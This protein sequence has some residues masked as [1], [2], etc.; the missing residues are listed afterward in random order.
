MPNVIHRT[1]SRIFPKKASKYASVYDA[2]E[3]NQGLTLKIDQDVE[4]SEPLM[5]QSY[6][7]LIGRK[8]RTTIKSVGPAITVESGNHN[9]LIANFAFVELLSN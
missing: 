8:E 3:A 4:L 7:R 1:W 9:V 6:T 5:P 2:L